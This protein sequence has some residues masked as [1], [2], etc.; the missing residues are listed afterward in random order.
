MLLITIDT[1][2]ISVSAGARPEHG[3]LAL[4]PIWFTDRIEPARRV[5]E[6]IGLRPR[7]AADG[8]GWIDFTADGGGVVALHSVS[9]ADTT[10]RPMIGLS[11]EHT[12]VDAL[13]VEVEERGLAAAVVDESYNRSLTVGSA[14]GPQIWVN[15]SQH[16][17]Y[18]YHR[19]E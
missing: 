16:D 13:A 1:V 4:Q 14:P 2:T 12:D 5:L 11:F 18:G 6:A 7:I 15:G 19:V 8:G 17:L 3:P 10:D 9:G